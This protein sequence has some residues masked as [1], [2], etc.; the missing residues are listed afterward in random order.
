MLCFSL[1]TIDKLAELRL[2][3]HEQR[4]QVFPVATGI[5]FLGFRVYPDFR[6]VKRKKVVSYYRRTRRKLKAFAVGGISFSALDASVRGWVNHVR[7]A[8][9][10]GLRRAM[11]RSVPIPATMGVVG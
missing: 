3:I 11:F 1:V 7:Y 10:W 6:R 4:A 9:S 2:S 5:P 8:D